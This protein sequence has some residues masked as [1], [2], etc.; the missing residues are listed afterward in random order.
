M[1]QSYEDF[2]SSIFLGFISGQGMNSLSFYLL[3]FVL[4]LGAYYT[5][6]RI[7]LKL[8]KHF[9]FAKK[10]HTKSLSM[11]ISLGFLL[12]WLLYQNYKLGHYQSDICKEIGSRKALITGYLNEIYELSRHPDKNKLD[13]ITEKS[14]H[15]LDD[16]AT[17]IK[18]NIG[19]SPYS[20]FEDIKEIPEYWK[21]TPEWLLAIKL[22]NFK[23]NLIVIEDNYCRQK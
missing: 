23:N 19:D 6:K 21:Y 20:D 8:K 1:P 22:K 15:W 13:E 5:I 12:V 4:G 3:L 9:A 7:I 2:W 17:W 18:K 10:I 16:T 14:G 11:I